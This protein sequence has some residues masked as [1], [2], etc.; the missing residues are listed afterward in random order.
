MP[1]EVHLARSFRRSLKNLLKKY[2]HAREDARLAL[3]ELTRS[4]ELGVL[5]PG[6]RGVRKVRVRNSD[7]QRG[8]SGGYRLL[9]LPLAQPQIIAALL[10]Y[11]KSDQA[12]VTRRELE[13][14][15]QELEEEA[16]E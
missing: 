4:P 8:K 1:Y 9:Y 12:D 11:A 16:E 7:L 5:I 3:D 2:P 10:M 6:G 15:L 13:E 14:L